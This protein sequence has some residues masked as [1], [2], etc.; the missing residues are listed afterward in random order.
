MKW[1]AFF[2]QSGSEIYQVSKKLG[3]APDR[4]IT[5]KNLGQVDKIN[6][7]LLTEYNGVWVFLPR[8]PTVDEYVHAI[9]HSVPIFDNTIITLHGYLRIIPA[10]LCG[11]YEMYNGHPGDIV[12]Y[13]ALKGFNPQQKAF[14][15]KLKTSGSVIHEVSAGVDEGKIVASSQCN[16]EDKSIEEVY[17]TLHSNSVELWYNFLKDKLK[18]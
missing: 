2:S 18:K 8:K 6:K 7:A 14:D 3:R 9:G 16:I 1:I 13:P 12:T 11:I 4:I 15:L 17:Q 10:N 5:N